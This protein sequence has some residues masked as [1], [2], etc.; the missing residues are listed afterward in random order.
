MK[1]VRLKVDHDLALRGLPTLFK[2]S[3][4]YLRKRDGA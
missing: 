4:M 2:F 1:T 3:L